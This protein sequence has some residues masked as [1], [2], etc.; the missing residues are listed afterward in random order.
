[1]QSSS[2]ETA[3]L[4]PRVASGD[5]SAL[6]TLYARYS[7]TLYALLLRILAVPEDAQEVLQE[8]FLQIWNRPKYFP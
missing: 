2:T 5:S 1:M 6:E 7:P 4:L 8:V 3:G